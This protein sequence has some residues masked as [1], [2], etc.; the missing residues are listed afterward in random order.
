MIQKNPLVVEK[1]DFWQD[2][3][4]GYDTVPIPQYCTMINKLK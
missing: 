2:P 4:S 3:D 1:A